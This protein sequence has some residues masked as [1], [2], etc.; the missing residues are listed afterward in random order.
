MRSISDRGASSF[1]ESRIDAEIVARPRVVERFA[2]ASERRIVLV[3]A[4]AGYGKSIALQQYLAQHSE[5]TIAIDVTNE[6]FDTSVISKQFRGT[7]VVDAFERASAETARGLVELIAENVQARWV[8]ATRAVDALPVGTWLA[9]GNCELPIGVCDLRF[10]DEEI[11]EACR[12]SGVGFEADDIAEIAAL[13]EGWPA[14]VAIAVRALKSGMAKRDVRTF[15]R[16][17]A[18]DYLRDQVYPVL[19]DRERE[20]LE[21]AAALPEIDAG[22]LEIAGFP[23]ALQ[24]L[25]V[26]RKHTG[27]LF[28]ENRRFR[29]STIVRDFLRRQTALA[30][31]HRYAAVNLRAAKALESAGQMEAALITYG[32]ARS[33]PDLLR[34]LETSGF[35]LLERGRAECVSNA[36]VALDEPSRRTNPRILALRGV[37]QSLAGKP[38]RAEA[39]LRRSIAHAKN[40]R[41]LV[42]TAT[43][44]LALL[45]AN[46]GEDITEL[47]NPIS[48][49]RRQSAAQRAEALSILTAHFAR[50]GQRGAAMQAMRRV[51]AI[52]RRLEPDSVRAKVFQR[53]G[54][55][56]MYV[57]ENGSARKLLSQ[58][59]ELA[60]EL[61]LFSLASRAYANLSNLMLHAFDDVEWQLWYAQKAAEEANKA[62]DAF[63]I[64]TSMLQLLVAEL[65]CGNLQ[66][67][68]DIE[69]RLASAKARDQSRSHYLVPPAALRLAWE[70]KFAEAHRLLAGSWRMLHH[71]IDRVVSGAECALFLAIDDKRAA[72][73]TLTEEILCLTAGLTTEGPFSHRSVATALLC[74]ALAE[75]ANG[76]LAHAERICGRI[77]T[78]TDDPVTA[79]IRRIGVETVSKIRSSDMATIETGAPLLDRL[80]PLGYAHLT[81]LLRA[82]FAALSAKTKRSTG[83]QL[84]AAEIATIRLLAEGLSPKEIAFRR[85]CTVKTIRNHIGNVISKLRCNGRVQ[86]LVL[87]RRAGILD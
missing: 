42:A 86:A 51:K 33:Q 43:F 31:S 58:A 76:R 46:R 87:S 29:T 70:G 72:S 74:C 38:V 61:E 56:A 37:L 13:T 35:D 82:T 28:E 62:G 80:E 34:I 26:T 9:Q 17:T 59:A 19:G 79:L 8:V 7:V 81:R 1:R 69:H 20:L 68:V 11:A 45:M 21:V 85:N 65:R 24:T 39:L 36:V 22:I 6:A 4:S 3:A 5:E 50:S 57:G 41:E 64:E 55:A 60:S 84:T 75:A 83:E 12:L 52:L 54:V 30:G 53:L 25:E 67:S 63:D 78:D 49:D 44:R 18:M 10:T 2:K 66:Q 23:D 73:V 47:L 77:G 14:A 48:L 27:L 16:E 71:D 32:P 15:V 40:D